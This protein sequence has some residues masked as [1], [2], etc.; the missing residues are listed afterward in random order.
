MLS[1]KTR[2]ILTV[3]MANK[4][5]AKELADAV[6]NGANLK[7]EAVDVIADPST[8]TAEDCANKINEL[9]LALKAAGLMA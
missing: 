9:I 8:A 5:S 2:K 4:A 6:D 7:A 1:E 3:A